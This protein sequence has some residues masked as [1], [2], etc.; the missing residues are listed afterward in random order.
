MVLEKGPGRRRAR[1]EFVSK[2]LVVEEMLK[3]R[4][5]FGGCLEVRKRRV[6]GGADRMDEEGA[7]SGS[8]LSY[9]VHGVHR[10]LTKNR[11]FYSFV[12]EFTRFTATAQRSQK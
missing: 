8:A 10:A 3:Q 9:G 7:K 5:G 4:T 12:L 11:R 2:W 6:L 1:S